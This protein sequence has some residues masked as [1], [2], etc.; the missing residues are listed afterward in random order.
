MVSLFKHVWIRSPSS[1]TPLY[2]VNPSL[3]QPLMEADEK[4]VHDLL[5]YEKCELRIQGMTCGACVEV[6][7]NFVNLPGQ[8]NPQVCS[9][10]KACSE[11]RKASTLSKL[12]FWQNEPS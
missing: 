6:S 11:I 10:L 7:K 1:D 9:L 4:V 5:Q 8:T 2:D 12:P 3:N